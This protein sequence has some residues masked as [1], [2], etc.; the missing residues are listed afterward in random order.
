M[1]CVSQRESN[2]ISQQSL[3][4]ACEESQPQWGYEE[5]H[6]PKVWPKYF[7]E[8][9]GSSQSPINLSTEQ[10][11]RK[12]IT[13][14]CHHETSTFNANHTGRTIEWSDT[15]TSN[16]LRISDEI[17]ILA[18]FHLHIPSEHT[19]NGER[20]NIEFQFV[21][22]HEET[23]AVAI[24]ALLFK[25]GEKNDF[26]ETLCT[27]LPFHNSEKSKRTSVNLNL[28]K[29][30]G[31]HFYYRGS[32][33]RPPC[34]EGVHWFVRRKM[35][36][37]SAWQLK[38]LALF[39]PRKN[40]RPIKPLGVHRKIFL[41]QFQK[42]MHDSARI[43]RSEMSSGSYGFEDEPSDST[44]YRLLVVLNDDDDTSHS[45][46]AAESRSSKIRTISKYSITTDV[47]SSFYRCSKTTGTGGTM[48]SDEVSEDVNWSYGEGIG[49]KDWEEFFPD[50][51]GVQ[52]SP[53]E[54]RTELLVKYDAFRSN[55]QFSYGH[56]VVM[57]ENNGKFLGWT[58]QRDPG[59]MRINGTKWTL[60]HFIIHTPAEHVIDGHRPQLELQLFHSQ[61]P[62]SNK[63]CIT[64]TLFEHNTNG[65]RTP[66]G[67]H[68]AHSK[69]MTHLSSK[70]TLCKDIGDTRS[71]SVNMGKLSTLG[72]YVHY[73]GSLTEPPC[74]EG[75]K[76]YVNCM[77]KS[78]PGDQLKTFR[79]CI[80]SANARPIQPL[81]QRKLF[82]LMFGDLIE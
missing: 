58:C 80:P 26:F 49:P 61:H 43:H 13:I 47:Y 73:K 42:Q 81:G 78:M 79:T 44:D 15:T 52:Q 60:R 82:E 59:F 28:A 6:G 36:Q 3:L 34:T 45:S 39:I 11:L 66:K 55:L 31:K 53:V 74:T 57:A 22:Y 63:Y 12:K 17:Y 48:L 33:T 64:S 21:H 75:Q 37:I 7:E 71:L 4:T 24:V 5:H 2:Y 67:K 8:A 27:A 30:E 62:S 29:F 68:L 77:I 76:W 54:I 10:V 38:Q 40:S 50:S 9:G 18:N 72:S 69:L 19:I 41:V 1:G 32:L 70:N 25:V 51:C 65:P 20:S 56:T 16:K 46:F 14:S 23:G 35:H